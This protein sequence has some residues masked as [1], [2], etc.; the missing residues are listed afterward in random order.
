MKQQ[1]KFFEVEYTKYIGGKNTMIVKG[2]D[3]VNALNNAKDIRRTGSD[4]KVV[5]EVSK[6]PTAVGGSG[7]KMVQRIKAG[8]NINGGF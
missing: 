8:K 1:I 4:F 3:E 5:K 6:Q 2:I 7:A